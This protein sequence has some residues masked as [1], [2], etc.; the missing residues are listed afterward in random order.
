M[1]I[2]TRKET[3]ALTHLFNHCDIHL[4][5]GRNVNTRAI[6]RIRTHEYKELHLNGL[7]TSIKKEENRQQHQKR[8]W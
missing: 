6:T 3:G 7:V 4:Q 1:H 2:Y 5:S 8:N